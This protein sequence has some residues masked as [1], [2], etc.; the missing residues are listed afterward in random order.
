MELESHGIQFG[1]GWR[2]LFVLVLY[3]TVLPPCREANVSPHASQMLPETF[4]QREIGTVSIVNFGF[5]F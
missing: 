1:K 3:R 2:G 5:W 4:V